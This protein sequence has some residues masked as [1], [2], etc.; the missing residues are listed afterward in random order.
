MRGSV[1]EV[2]PGSRAKRYLAGYGAGAAGNK[3]HG[4]VVDAATGATLVRFTQ[5]RRSGGSFKFGGGSDIEVMQDS[6]HAIGEDVVHMIQAF[7]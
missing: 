4:E 1:D 7:Q 6:I 2:S 5:E 3:V